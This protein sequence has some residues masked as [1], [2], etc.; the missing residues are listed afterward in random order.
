LTTAKYSIYCIA[1]NRIPRSYFRTLDPGPLRCPE[2]GH[3]VK[4]RAQGVSFIKALDPGAETLNV[5]QQ[6]TKPYNDYAHRE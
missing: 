2:L 1:L 4:A 6:Y 3:P 5:I